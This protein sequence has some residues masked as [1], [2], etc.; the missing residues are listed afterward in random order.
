M[1][2]RRGRGTILSQ[3]TAGTAA[4][5]GRPVQ[6]AMD[7]DRP[8]NGAPVNRILP[9]RHFPLGATWDGEGTNFVVFAERASRVILCLYAD[10]D[11]TR[12]VAA[13]SLPEHTAHVW[14]GYV[15]GVA[16][17]QRYGFRA[18]GDYKPERGLRFNP[19][20]L[21]VD[22][23]AR[24]VSGSVEWRPEIFGYEIGHPDADLS[25]SDADSAPFVPKGIV[26][27]DAFDW[28]GD[29]PLNTPWHRTVIYEAHVKGM[30]M[31]HP[32][33][34]EPLRGTY[35]G[36]AQPAVIAHLRELGVTA[37]ELLPVHDFADEGHLVDKGLTNYWG[38]N[39]TN[40]F[41]P[42]AR[43]A[44][45]RD[46]GG[47]V[48]EFRAM[49]K[50]LHAAG[51]EVILDVVYNHTS[52]GNELGPT[53]S[54]RG[55]GNLTYYRL[56]ADD[57]RYYMNYT[58]TGNTLNSRHPQVLK[59]IM[60]SLR[61]WVQEMHVDGFRF[62]LASALA[63]EMHEV[64]RLSSFFDVIHQ[65]PVLSHVKLIAEPWDVGDGGYQVGNFPVLWAEWNDRYRDTTR[66]FWRGDE[67]QM[68]ELGY[69]LTGSSDLYEDAGRRPNAS[70]NFI[71]AHD[72]FTLHDLV[73]YNDRHNEA[74]GENNRDGHTNNLSWNHGVEGETD[75]AEIIELRERQ[76]RNLVATLLLSQGVPMLSAG[77]EIGRTQRGN[78]NAYAQDNELSWLDW[79]LDE[80]R[81]TLLDFTRRVSALRHAHPSLR[82]RKF[83]QGRAIHGSEIRDITWLRPDGERMDESAWDAEWIK[84]FGMLLGGAALDERD[85]TGERV[86][87]ATL[88]L[89]VNA[90]H[91]S[92]DFT[93]PQL[94][95][96]MW[97][98]VLY[99]ADVGITEDAP[100]A[101][102]AGERFPA[103]ARS[104][105][106]LR[107][108]A[109]DEG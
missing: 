62:D 97:E 68:A 71:T 27:D 21:L 77:D 76:K 2:R 54:F 100:R 18:E 28:G 94:E 41:S 39:T 44:A 81:R 10:D 104:L 35:A 1:P 19:A 107:W 37:I 83:F 46:R 47:Q 12:E 92:V 31:L 61:Y 6:R 7:H 11:H 66:R 43:Y 91:E 58:G 14:H 63:R 25:R 65:D 106:L 52:E 51:I 109:V 78:N 105:A 34:P 48:R 59:L 85:E 42:A 13:F 45:T 96:C 102:A 93:L 16:P 60:D 98:V 101:L 8:N 74:N 32:E 49:V 26:L 99:T 29:R 20:K 15:P 84:S 72:G 53:L 82:R 64:H 4:R 86:T 17:G 5:I 80:P 24:A 95:G 67:D 9:G 88:L 56:V 23:Y 38:Y 69:R 89:L 55:L 73:T 36:L 33:V 90:H 57:P 70:I 103:E 87:D 75:D 22:P 40:F 50:A 30:T 108:S 3:P 79:D